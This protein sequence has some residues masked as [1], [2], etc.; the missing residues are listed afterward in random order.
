M[1]CLYSFSVFYNSETTLSFSTWILQCLNPVFYRPT[2]D[3]IGQVLKGGQAQ[4][5]VSYYIPYIVEACL[6]P[7]LLV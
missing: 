7:L 5:V 2:E 6:H 1:S 4:L 3:T